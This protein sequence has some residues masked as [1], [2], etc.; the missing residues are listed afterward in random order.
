M[1]HMTLLGRFLFAS[2]CG[3][4]LAGAVH[5][6]VVLAAPRFAESDAIA[7]VME[8]PN[9]VLTIQKIASSLP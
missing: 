2:L 1:Q 7:R 9:A 8:M 3:I 5:V 4:V 6:F